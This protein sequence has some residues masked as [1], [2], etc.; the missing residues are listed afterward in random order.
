MFLRARSNAATFVLLF[1]AALAQP[2]IAQC[3]ARAETNIIYVSFT[4]CDPGNTLRVL[5]GGEPVTIT[6]IP[7]RPKLWRGETLRTFTLQERELK[8]DDA[9]IP[10]VRFACSTPAVPH[11]AGECVA[12]Y[13]VACETLWYLE[14]KKVPETASATISYVRNTPATAVPPCSQP[15]TIRQP[16]VKVPASQPYHREIELGRNESVVVKVDKPRLDIPLDLGCFK[17]RNEL[18]LFDVVPSAR[19]ELASVQT[20][21]AMQALKKSLLLDA[22][23]DLLFTKKD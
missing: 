11:N 8:V 16:A 10:S 17:R 15:G 21:P 7:N 23:T 22:V 13:Q 12:H 3:T 19:S 14:V 5:V 20:N 6:R 4:A 9:D 1:A 18:T 2:A